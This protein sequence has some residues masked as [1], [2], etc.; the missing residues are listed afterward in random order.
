MNEGD[1]K[2]LKF[3][4]GR[5]EGS[6]QA[7]PR[8]ARVRAVAQ[9]LARVRRWRW[10]SWGGGLAAASLMV[11]ALGLLDCREACPAGDARISVVELFRSDEEPVEGLGLGD[12]L[13]AWQD[14]PY[15]ELLTDSADA[16]FFV[17]Y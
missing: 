8:V 2:L 17:E 15:R 4:Q 5:L 11:A 1:Q 9:R 13:L 12:V 6:V 3:V 7:S 14:A 10:W 16:S